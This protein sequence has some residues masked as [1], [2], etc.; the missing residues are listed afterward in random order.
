LLKSLQ[1]PPPESGVKNVPAQAV[2]ALDLVLGGNGRVSRADTVPSPTSVS[3]L[4]AR[5]RRR[6]FGHSLCSQPWAIENELISSSRKGDTRMKDQIEP[7]ISDQLD[8]G[9]ISDQVDPL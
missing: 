2:A 3:R 5:I 1:S 4:A 8:P 7:V 9:L 6:S